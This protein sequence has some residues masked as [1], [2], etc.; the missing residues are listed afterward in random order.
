MKNYTQEG[1]VCLILG[2]ANHFSQQININIGFQCTIY[3]YPLF[4]LKKLPFCYLFRYVVI[5]FYKFQQF[6]GMKEGTLILHT[7]CKKN[8]IQWCDQVL[9]KTSRVLQQNSSFFLCQNKNNT[10]QANRLMGWLLQL[11][12]YYSVWMSII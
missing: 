2:D 3:V 8:C 10:R 4:T 7:Q 1:W 11:F 9:T 5:F 6:S 12:Q